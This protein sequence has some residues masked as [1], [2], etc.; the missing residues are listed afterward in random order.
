MEADRN[1]V[2]KP[3]AKPKGRAV[4]A[5]SRPCRVDVRLTRAEKAKWDRAAKA[6]RRTV[7][8]L[9]AEIIEKKFK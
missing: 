9:L 7:T 6:T 8:S 4:K 5:V 2:E 1:L 3:K